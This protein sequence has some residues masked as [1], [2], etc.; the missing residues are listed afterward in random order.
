MLDP[1]GTVGDVFG[2]E[3]NRTEPERQA[4][5]LTRFCHSSNEATSEEL[6]VQVQAR[7]LGLPVTRGTPVPG[8]LRSG[9]C[10]SSRP[11]RIASAT[12][13]ARSDTP[14]FS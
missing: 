6:T 4:Q 13:A 3:P 1:R 5:A 9:A 12:A 14:S 8:P 2:T 7:F 10:Y 11:R